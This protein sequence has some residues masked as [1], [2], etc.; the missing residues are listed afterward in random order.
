MRLHCFVFEVKRN[1]FE[2]IRAKLIPCLG[3][4]EYGVT[5]RVCEISPFFRIA[6]VEAQLHAIRIAKAKPFERTEPTAPLSN[7]KQMTPPIPQV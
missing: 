2:N 5:K 6:N 1:R 3:L 7:F 4:S